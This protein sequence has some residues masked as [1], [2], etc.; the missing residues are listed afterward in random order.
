MLPIYICNCSTPLLQIWKVHL[1]LVLFFL[2]HI[3][4]RFSWLILLVMCHRRSQVPTTLVP[5]NQQKYSQGH[6]EEY[7]KRI[8]VGSGYH[9]LFKSHSF[10]AHNWKL[11]AVAEAITELILILLSY[12]WVGFI[13]VVFSIA[14]N[15]SY[16]ATLSPPKKCTGLYVLHWNVILGFI[17]LFFKNL[18]AS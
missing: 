16:N 5:I 6:V 3:F 17:Y 18:L 13:G 12:V 4:F 15:F 10:G 14:T 1:K 8:V 11:N 9:I 2:S 7:N